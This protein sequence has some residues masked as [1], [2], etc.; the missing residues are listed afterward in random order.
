MTRLRA[1]RVGHRLGQFSIPVIVLAYAGLS[2]ICFGQGEQAPA[3]EVVTRIRDEVINML[4]ETSIPGAAIAVV[5]D[6]NIIW[7]KVY[8][9]VYGADSRPVDVNTIFSIQSMS[10]GFTAL[11]V[12]IAVQDGLVDLDTPI[13]EYLPDFTVNSIYDEN[14]EEVI[15]LRHLLSHRAGFTHEAPFGSNFDDRNDFLKHIESISSTWL[16]YPV[17]YR[18]SYSNLGIDLAGYILQVR[19]GKKFELYVKEKVFNPLGMNSSSLDMGVIKQRENRAIGHGRNT[20]SIPIHIP[21]IPAG[22]V[23]TNVRDMT[24]YAQF[25]INK[26]VVDGRRILR[27]DLM[28]QMHTIQF[29]RDNQRFGYCMGLIREPVSDSYGIYHAG[30]GYGFASIMLM[31]PEKNIG[32]VLLTNSE[33]ESMIWSLRSL[34]KESIS[35][36]FGTTPVE[37]PG[38]ELMIQLDPEDQRVQ[39]IMGRYGDEQGYAIGYEDDVLGLRRIGQNQFYPLTFYDDGGELVGIYGNF[40]EI[41]FLPPYNGRRGSLTAVDRRLSNAYFDVRDFNDSPTDP[42]GPDEPHWSE[43]LG[44]YELLKNGDPIGTFSVSIRNGYLYAGECKCVEHEPGLFFA[45]DGEAIDFRSDPQTAMN[46]RI[47]MCEEPK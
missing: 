22:G 36:R 21:M 17:G 27:A 31:F 13:K 24:R 9:N 14:P 46:I 35:E 8:G 1:L 2:S 34:V 19:S 41:R 16:R 23:Y 3:E 33:E 25:H 18:Y 20:D 11:A 28:K 7:D 12:L 15:T 42:P 6:K 26:G 10:K 38:T 43:Y 4:S 32:I 44:N 40:S 5:D 30:A 47:R 39:A 37:E 45:Y 29:A